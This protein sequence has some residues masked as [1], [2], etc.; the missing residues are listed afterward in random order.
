MNMMHIT[1]GLAGM[2]WWI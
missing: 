2:G 1:N